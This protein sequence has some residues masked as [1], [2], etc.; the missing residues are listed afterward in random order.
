MNITVYCGS[1]SNG[2]PFIEDTARN[3]GLWIAHEGHTLIYGGS[4]IGLMGI[5]ARSVLEEGGKVHGVELQSFA[6]AGV[7]Q[8]GLSALDVVATMPQR[9][10]RMIELGDVFVALPGGVGTLE[11]I[12]EIM[13]RIRIGKAP[14]FCSFLNLGGF[15]NPLRQLLQNMLEHNFIEQAD[16]ERFLFL[17]SLDEFIRVARSEQV[18]PHV[19][20]STAAELKA[21]QG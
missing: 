4:S 7:L 8:E 9:K 19:A 1:T 16:Y 15:Y 2:D 5:V 17:N 18:R 3:L 11:E 20:F 12:S 6:D 21:P 10:T 13:S 14:G